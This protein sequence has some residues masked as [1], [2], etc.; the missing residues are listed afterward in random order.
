LARAPSAPDE[1]IVRAVHRPPTVDPKPDNRR[2]D[3]PGLLCGQ[4]QRPAH[5]GQQHRL[6]ALL[7]NKGAMAMQNSLKQLRCTHWH[8]LY[9]CAK[10]D[11]CCR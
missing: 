2:Y 10:G 4:G 11:S 3:R 8:A 6:R 5:K 1:H 7:P 9:M